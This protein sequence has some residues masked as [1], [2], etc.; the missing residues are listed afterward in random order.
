MKTP[1]RAWHAVLAAALLASAAPQARADVTVLNAGFD[2]V[3][4]LGGWLFV[5]QSTPPGSLWFQGNAGIFPAQAGGADAY[6]AANYLSAAQGNGTIDNW[7]ITPELSLPGTATLSFYTRSAATP[8]FSDHLEVRYSTGGSS[9]SDFSNVL[10]TVGGGGPYPADWRQY[11]LTADPGSTV[12]FAFRYTGPAANAEYIGLDTVVVNAV[13]EPSAWL[14][15]AAGLLL[16]LW[17][18]RRR[19]GP[20]RP[21]AGAYCAAPGGPARHGAGMRNGGWLAAAAML[22]CAQGAAAAGQDGMILVRDAET[23]TLR[24]PTAAE[25]AALRSQ[26]GRPPTVAPQVYQRPDGTRQSRVNSRQIYAVATR[27]ADGT[28][29]STCVQGEQ[30]AEA[31]LRQ[32]RFRTQVGAAS[33]EHSHERH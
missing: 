5:N 23:G 29:A 1:T 12:R 19:P 24:P 18:A 33:E 3:G 16:V 6:I 25:H 28:L 31:A 2:D 4:A 9:I 32:E 21:A 22:A 30:A 14:M 10:L 11:T 27:G 8:G 20:A 26:Q 17:R 15:V 7:L 13:P